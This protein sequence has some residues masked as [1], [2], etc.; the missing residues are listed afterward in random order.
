MKW[1][2]V[3]SL[4]ALMASRRR[5]V[6]DLVQALFDLPRHFRAGAQRAEDPARA[7]RRVAASHEHTRPS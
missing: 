2:L 3:A 4:V 7:A 1:L 5:L 6:G